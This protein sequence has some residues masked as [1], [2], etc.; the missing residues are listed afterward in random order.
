M[1]KNRDNT[2]RRKN[3]KDSCERCPEGW[4]EGPGMNPLW[5][6]MKRGDVIWQNRQPGGYVIVVRVFDNE[7][8][9]D[10][11]PSIWTDHDYPLLRV[12]HST[13][14]LIDEAIRHSITKMS[15]I[16]FTATEDYR[17]RV[18]QLGEQPEKVFN[19]GAP[20]IDSILKL[21]LLDK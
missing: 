3:T 21:D 11:D 18:I 15:H 12:L 6:D 2:V 14:G 17:K 5:E 1:G 9:Y 13:E 4:E 16:H 7:E 19:Y 20:G 8:C 10:G